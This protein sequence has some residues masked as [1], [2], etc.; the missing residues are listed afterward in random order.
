MYWKGKT[1]EDRYLCSHGEKQQKTEQ[2]TGFYRVSCGAELSRMAW[3]LRNYVSWSWG[4]LRDWWNSIAWYSSSVVGGV[5]FFFLFV[6][7]DLASILGWSQ[8]R[9]CF[10]LGSGLQLGARVCFPWPFMVHLT[11]WNLSHT[12]TIPWAPPLTKPQDVLPNNLICFCILLPKFLIGISPTFSFGA[13]KTLPPPCS[14]LISW[15][16]HLEETAIKLALLFAE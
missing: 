9:L 7:V 4:K 16:L 12:P 14:G 11:L 10:C 15:V 8:V 3:D 6:F 2:K 13:I 1:Q 5:F